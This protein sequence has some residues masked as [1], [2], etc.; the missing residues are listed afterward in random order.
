MSSPKVQ[1]PGAAVLPCSDG[2]PAHTEGEGVRTLRPRR[3]AAVLGLCTILMATC[4]AYGGDQAVVQIDTVEVTATPIMAE[5][6]VTLYGGRTTSVGW[7]QVA[8]LNAHDLPSALRLLPGV[9]I[10]RYNLLGS[11]GGGEG[12]SVYVRGQGAGR[13]GSEIKVYVDGAPREVGVWSHPVM[14]VV[15]TDYA[16]SMEVHKGPQPNEYS[17]TFGTVDLRTMQRI[18]QG[19][20]TMFSL[21]FGEWSSYGGMLRHGGKVDAFDYYLGASYRQSEGHRPHADGEMGSLFMRLGLDVTG[22]VHVG[23]VLQHTDNWSR[24]PG[25]IEEPTPERDKFATNTLTHNLRFDHDGAGFDGYALLYYEDGRIRWEKD[26]INGPETPAGNSDTD[27]SNYGLRFSEDVTWHSLGITAGLE[28]EDEGGEFRNS[29][30]YGTVPFKYEGRFTTVAPS[31][32]ARYRVGLRTGSLI[33]S[34]GLRYYSHSRFSSM[35]APHAGLIFEWRDYKIFTTYAR[36]VSYPGVY[37]VGVASETVEELEAEVLDHVEAGANAAWDTW[38]RLQVSVFHDRSDNLMQWT[39]DGLTNVRDYEINGFEIS[40]TLSPRRRFSLL[41]AFTYLGPKR[42]RTPRTPA[43]SLSAGVNYEPVSKVRLNLDLEYVDE[44]YAFNA[45]S[46]EGE[47]ADLE[48]LPSYSLANAS[49]ALV[50][51]EYTRFP[52]ELSIAVENITDECYAFQPGYPMPGR[53]VFVVARLGS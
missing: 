40:S 26:H 43:F 19:H 20:E 15:P 14:D 6:D 36:G 50:L 48:K 18:Q 27:W 13:P 17:G 7:R 25:R 39:P 21:T 5:E 37:S 51:S 30:V 12:G 8:D 11:Y 2:R 45:R 35:A 46:G 22:S 47:I 33:T 3:F 41:M 32:A 16:S 34:M 42:E 44:Q 10:S 38:L 52:C 53:T 49:V 9:T 31:L 4:L 1:S 24:D 28:V 23:Y 29:T